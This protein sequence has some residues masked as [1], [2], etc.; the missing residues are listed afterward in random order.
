MKIVVGSDHAGFSLKAMVLRHLADGGHNVEDV[1]S[2]DDLPVD[3][4]DIAQAVT[5]RILSG[6]VERGLLLCGT[7]V[8]AS[9]AA[10]KMA[11]IRAACAT[12]CTPLTS[13]WSMTT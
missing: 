10:N 2:H 9:I 12:T 13:R 7:G 8:G 4:P 6:Q 5:G 11:G 3:F 1:G